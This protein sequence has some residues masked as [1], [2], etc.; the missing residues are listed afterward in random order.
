LGLIVE[1][2]SSVEVAECWK[3]AVGGWL[4]FRYAT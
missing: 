3:V 4:A 1:E 2:I